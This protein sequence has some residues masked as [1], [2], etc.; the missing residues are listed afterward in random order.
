MA[1]LTVKNA[2]VNLPVRLKNLKRFSVFFVESIEILVTQNKAI[3]TAL[4]MLLTRLKIIM[5][6][7]QGI[8]HDN[9]LKYQSVACE[10]ALQGIL[11]AGQ[12]KGGE[13]DNYASGI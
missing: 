12:E 7:T 1:R 11:A 2:L 8:L 5:S 4:H 3:G 6:A 10:Q 13:L 9:H